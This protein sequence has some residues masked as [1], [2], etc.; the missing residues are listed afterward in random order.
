[1]DLFRLKKPRILP[2]EEK[3]WDDETREAF[4]NFKRVKNSPIKYK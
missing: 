3:D 2:Y 1:M 4:E